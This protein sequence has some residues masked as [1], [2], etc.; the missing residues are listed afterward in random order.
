MQ[1]VRSYASVPASARGAALAIGNFDGVH[2]GHQAVLADAALMAHARGVPAGALLFDPHPRLLFQPDKPLF[3]LT[4]LD[5]KLRLLGLLALDV[6]VVLPFDRALASL[7]AE[8]F[9]RQVLVEGLGVSHV[10]VGHDFNFGRG[11]AGND[12]LLDRMGSE[13]GFGVT[14]VP[15]VKGDGQLY[16]SSSIRDL[17][18]QGDVRAAAERLGYWWRI[19][20]TVVGG[21]KRGTGLG[22]PTANIEISPGCGLRHG[23]YAARV[24]AE[25]TRHSAAVYLGKRPTFDNG[26]PVLECFLLDFDGNLYGKRI[27]VELID[28]LR[29]DGAFPG[30]EAL[31]AQMRE[32]CRRAAETLAALDKHDPMLAHRLGHALADLA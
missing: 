24:T 16:S 5:Q 9:V 27:E 29:P 22:F 31:V 1:V 15:A 32:D 26:A 3:L 20:G 19:A 4:D 23:I 2:R 7:T 10:V 30:A 17:L 18:R 6:A 12:A 8:D 13:L 11:R 28:F 14:V 25:G 21:A